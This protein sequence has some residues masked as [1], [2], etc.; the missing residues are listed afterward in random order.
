MVVTLADV[1][2]DDDYIVVCVDVAGIGGFV[3]VFVVVAVDDADV[4]PVV[5]VDA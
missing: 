4:P 1:A 5:Y 2:F 3:V